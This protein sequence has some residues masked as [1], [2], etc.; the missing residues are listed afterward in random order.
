MIAR[1]AFR[2]IAHQPWRTAM[3]F[4]GFGIGVGVMIVLLAVGEAMLVQARDE[5]LVGGGQVTVLP[6]GLD[7]EVMK[8][9]GVG[10][11]FFSIPNARFVQRQLLASPRLAGAVRAV[12]PQ[13]E[14]KTLWM[15]PLAR[16]RAGGPAASP[17]PEWSVRATGE[18]PSAT[19]AVGAMPDLAS[20]A[21]E[22]DEGDRRWRDPTP[23]ELRD[24]LDHFHL[25]PRDR[26]AAERE[27]WGEWHYVNVLWDA[28]RRWAFLTWMVAGDVPDGRWGGQLI[29]TVHA[30]GERARRFT[31][32]VPPSAVRYSTEHADLVVGPGAVRVTDRGTYHVTGTARGEGPDRG[33]VA[34]VDLE[35]TPAP[36]AYFPGASLGDATPGGL[37]SGYAVPALR[38][39]A[40]GTVCV[41]GA[42][43]RIADAPAYHD[44]NW[45]LWRRVEWEWGE[46]RAGAFA[47]L[48]GR[49][50]QAD[51]SAARAPL[52][53]YL[54][55]SLGFRALF[56]PRAIT[57]EDARTI[58]VD[59]RAVR[60]P[61]RGTMTDVRGADTLVVTLEV[62][63]AVG[64][65]TRRG[66]IERGDSQAA[67]DVPRPYFIQ[68][69]GRATLRGRLGG[70]P[71]AATGP[72]FFETY[73]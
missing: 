72:S 58:Q 53:L 62:E 59:G 37:V 73:R 20:G 47:M 5:K 35:V 71:L 46:A 67:R 15:R 50:R 19:R 27:S 13:V 16:G 49:V 63:D 23:R 41:D 43:A 38:A 57:W 6:E 24:D 17:A 60:V 69:K 32:A 51:S 12:A 7:L 40:S 48:F 33:V 34:T 30:A 14:G 8:T 10:G 52:F 68:L 18:I 45:G 70:V 39:E 36:R 29:F 66:L 26:S 21:W 9:G 2:N 28:G 61:Q 31:L 25:P 54:V 44:H 1:L 55:D 65:D 11:L 22:D 3:L 64:T 4:A 56:R 42:C